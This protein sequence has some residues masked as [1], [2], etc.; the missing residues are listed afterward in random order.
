MN[1]SR[2]AGTVRGINRKRKHDAIIS[3]DEDPFYRVATTYAEWQFIELVATL[4][5]SANGI[6]R[7]PFAKVL[8]EWLVCCEKGRNKDER[9]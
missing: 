6:K 3:E 1:E 4:F 9:E 8:P 7:I 5:A 2:I